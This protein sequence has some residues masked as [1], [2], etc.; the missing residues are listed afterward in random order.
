[1]IRSSACLTPYTAITGVLTIFP[2]LYFTAP[3]L[4]L[5]IFYIY[6]FLAR[7]EG[8]KR[9]TEPSI[10]CLSHTPRQGTEP[11]TQACALTENGTG[12]PSLCRTMPKQLR[13]AGQGPRL[14]L[15]PQFVHLNPSHLFRPVPP[16]GDHQLVLRIC[17]YFCGLFIHLLFVRFNT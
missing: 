6:L 5:K 7:G 10:G 11:T 3:W 15:Q 16:Y 9:G 12:D 17:V 1:M 13:H 14:F 4:F 2:M 8:R